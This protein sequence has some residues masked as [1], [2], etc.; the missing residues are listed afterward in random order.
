MIGH[1]A[2]A[3]CVYRMG[4]KRR[5]VFGLWITLAV[6]DVQPCATY[7]TLAFL[8]REGT[9]VRPIKIFVV[10]PT[11]RSRHTVTCSLA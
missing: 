1:T 2:D 3:T 7:Q 5:V 9:P 10:A 8:Y 6:N 11:H 4:Q